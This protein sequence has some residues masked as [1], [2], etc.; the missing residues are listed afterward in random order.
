MAQKIFGRWSDYTGM[1]EDWYSYG[2]EN[3]QPLKLQPTEDE[4]LF[5]SYGGGSYEGDATVVFRRDGKL[6]EVSGSHCSCYGLEGQ[7]EPEETS[8]AA[9][10]AKGKKE[11]GSSYYFLSEHDGEAYIAYW[12][13]VEELQ[14]AEAPQ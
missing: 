4:L 9:L 5:A 12:Q 3:R 8:I 10:A 11:V 6:Y 1:I 13:M 7:W 14:K 2:G